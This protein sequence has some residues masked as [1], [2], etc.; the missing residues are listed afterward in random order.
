MRWV[1]RLLALALF[2]GVLMAGWQ[3]AAE[4]GT[5]VRM[6]YLV[7]ELRDV[8]LWKLSVLGPLVSARLDHGDRLAWF[9]ETSAWR[10]EST[11][12]ISLR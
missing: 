9:Q 10:R 2:V 3:F 8:A 6:H 7:G 4:N 12:T 11:A 1:R 5:P